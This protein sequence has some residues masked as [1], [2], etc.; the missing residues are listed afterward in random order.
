V[1]RDIP[2]IE[3]RMQLPFTGPAKRDRDLVDRY[4]EPR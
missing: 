1:P 4:R 2:E 3:A